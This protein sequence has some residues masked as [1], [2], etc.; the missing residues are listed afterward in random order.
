MGDENPYVMDIQPHIIG[1]DVGIGYRGLALLPTA[2]TT[3][4]AYLGGVYEWM[5]YYRDSAG[6]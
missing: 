5:S 4:W 6:T 3:I 2:D 1:V